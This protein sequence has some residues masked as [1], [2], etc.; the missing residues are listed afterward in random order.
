MAKSFLGFSFGKQA[1]PITQETNHTMK[2]FAFSTPF[3][4][5]GSGNLSLPH[6]NKYYTQ[7]NIV[8]FGSDNLYPQLLN[9]LYYTSAIHGACLDFITNSVIGGG[10][11]WVNKNISASEKVD[12]LTFEK[13]NK[14]KKLTEILTKDYI[15]HRRVCVLVCRKNGKFLKFKRFDPSTIRNEVNLSKFVYSNDWSRGSFEIKEY[16]RYNKASKEDETLYVYQDE[17]PGQ[18][19][20]PIPTYNS[21]L[22]WAYLDGE[23]S[24][25]HKS[26]IQNSVFPS[27]V[28]RRPKEFGSIDEVNQFKEEIS[29]KTG[30]SNGGRVLVLT[31]NG[32]DDVPEFVPV[33]ANQN[34]KLFEGT[35]KELKDNICFAHKINPAIMGI[36]VAGSLGNSEELNMSYMIYEKNVVKSD[37]DTMEEIFNELIDIADLKQTLTINDYQIIGEQV[38]V[39]DEKSNKINEALKSM[40]PAAAQKV[41]DSMTI[42]ELRA[43]AN[44]QIIKG[45][46][47]NA[48]NTAIAN[49]EMENESTVNDALKGLTAQENMDMMR[50]IRDFNKGKLPESLALKRLIAYGLTEDDAKEILGIL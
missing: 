22:N 24:F 43:L 42:N 41:L 34:D 47:T 25:F 28:I 7:N 15:I 6:V 30:A 40:L 44:L 23:Q 31:G 18:D 33:A 39:L 1:E 20:Y 13:V 35:A 50:I 3:G 21:I 2:S 16:K 19:I 14:F 37:R 46:D 27:A 45:G 4:V 9:Q 32:M 10:Y 26:N 49:Q 29:S 17:T 38:I 8:R 48:T 11:S 12:I 36:K 5:I